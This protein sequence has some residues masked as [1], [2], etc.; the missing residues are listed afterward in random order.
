MAVP[1]WHL[2]F[3][4]MLCWGLNGTKECLS[5]GAW[6]EGGRGASPCPLT[7]PAP[8]ILCLWSLAEGQEGGYTPQICVRHAEWRGRGAGGRGTPPPAP[9]HG[10]HQGSLV[11]GGEGTAPL[12]FCA[13]AASSSFFFFVPVC[14]KHIRSGSGF[15]FGSQ[16][17]KPHS[18]WIIPPAVGSL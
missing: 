9:P 18:N 7:P 12:G 6:S 5:C 17:V 10:D 1:Q 11:P 2:V 8:L 13:A 15:C 3:L 4:E 16:Q 14:S